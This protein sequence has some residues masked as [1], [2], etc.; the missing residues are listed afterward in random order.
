MI[1]TKMN[2]DILFGA[3]VIF[4]HVESETYLMCS[5]QCSDFRTD[6]FKLEL[7]AQLRSSVIFKIQ[8]FHNY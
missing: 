7:S 1:Q 6:S 3:E 5:D 8:P 2:E 4:K